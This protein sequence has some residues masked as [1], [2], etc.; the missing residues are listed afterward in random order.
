M[1]GTHAFVT[2]SRYTWPRGPCSDTVGLSRGR[3]R[4][5]TVELLGHAS[6][7]TDAVPL[8]ACPPNQPAEGCHRSEDEGRHEG[9]ERAN[10]D[11]MQ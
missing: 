4:A 10:E 7:D 11:F 3:V 2:Q 9:A 6:I 1:R 5:Y 8:W